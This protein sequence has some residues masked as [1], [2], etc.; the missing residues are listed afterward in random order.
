MSFSLLKESLEVYLSNNEEF[1]GVYAI[2]KKSIFNTE[3]DSAQHKK[4]A[5]SG[6]NVSGE[7]VSDEN[8]SADAAEMAEFT[9]S[10]D[11]VLIYVSREN[12]AIRV[13]KFVHFD[14]AIYNEA[15]AT[16]KNKLVSFNKIYMLNNH[17]AASLSTPIITDGVFKGII[18]IHSSAE[19][20]HKIGETIRPLKKGYG[21]LFDSSDQV[22]YHPKEKYL[23]KSFS[24]VKKESNKERIEAVCR[25]IKEQRNEILS[26]V[27][28]IIP[29]ILNG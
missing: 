4:V 25:L 17:R 6:E 21:M 22:V 29:T 15:A 20:L 28:L 7:N 24:T 26:F 27:I 18:G 1:A 3:T 23:F 12:G 11:R 10:N 14:E 13:R 9:D 2:V 8:V 19:H 16:L 5:V